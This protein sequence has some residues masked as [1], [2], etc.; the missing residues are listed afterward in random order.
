MEQ[1]IKKHI[2]SKYAFKG[3]KISDKGPTAITEHVETSDLDEFR[4]EGPT[5]ETRTIETSDSDEMVLDPTKGAYIIEL[6]D[7]DEFLLI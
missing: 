7:D 3:E 5:V 1:K 4:L 6:S 2:L